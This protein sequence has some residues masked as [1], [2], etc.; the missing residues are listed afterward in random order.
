MLSASF[1]SF[2]TRFVWIHHPPMWKNCF[3]LR[4][5]QFHYSLKHRWDGVKTQDGTHRTRCEQGPILGSAR[6]R[7]ETEWRSWCTG[8]RFE[9]RNSQFSFS[10]GNMLSS[11]HI[12]LQREEGD[13]ERRSG[14]EQEEL[15][16]SRNETLNFNQQFIKK[17]PLEVVAGHQNKWRIGSCWSEHISH[18]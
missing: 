11:Q 10:N 3:E 1:Y 18:A 17:N 13:R 6:R 15:E 16:Y 2:N 9:S 12:R 4:T 14:S 7:L 5:V 8:G